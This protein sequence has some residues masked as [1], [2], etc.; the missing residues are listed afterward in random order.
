MLSL[1]LLVVP[2]HAGLDLLQ[3]DVLP[4][5]DDLAEDAPIAV[6]LGV[7]HLDVLS[8]DQL[9]Q[10]LL[11]LGAERLSSFRCIDALQMFLVLKLRECMR[12]CAEADAKLSQMAIS[13]NS[14]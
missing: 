10:M 4:V 14:S 8:G 5:Q 11:R 6:V 9:G 2:R 7:V 3:I 12:R 1:I 13:T